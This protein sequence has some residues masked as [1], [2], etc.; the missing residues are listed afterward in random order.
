MI[1]T[2]FL[3]L[4][5]FLPAFR[6]LRLLGQE[7]QG[8]PVSA[9]GL[10]DRQEK[11][12]QG[13]ARGRYGGRWQELTDDQLAALQ[14]RADAYLERLSRRHLREGLVVSLRLDGPTNGAPVAY[15]ALELSAAQTGYLLGVEAL[16][17]AVTRDARPMV[18]ISNLLT[19]VDRLLTSGPRPGFL[20]VFVGAAADPAYRAVFPGYGGEDPKRPGF[21]RWAREGTGSNSV[22]VVW[23]GG[24]DREAYAALNLGLGLVHKLVR[25]TTIRERVTR[26]VGMMLERLREDGWRID[27]GCGRTNFVTP[28]LK[29]ALLCTG[30]NTEPR[31]YLAPYRTTVAEALE[32]PSPALTRYGV[33]SRNVSTFANLFL[34]ARLDPDSSRV[35]IFRQRLTQLW[36]DAEPD[37]NPVLAALFMDAFERRPNNSGA[38]T[39]LQGILAQFPD[40]PRVRV[41]LR[42]SDQPPVR[43]TANGREWVRQAQ[44]LD[45]RP[46]APFQWF[47]TPYRLADDAAS[48]APFVEHPG[49]DFLLAYWL[50][51]DAGLLASAARAEEST[52]RRTG[53]GSGAGENGTPGGNAV[54]GRTNPP[55]RTGG[56]AR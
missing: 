17:F 23:L 45:R 20:P 26:S 15:E 56:P 52:V 35:E 51:K 22:P 37:L 19:G 30:A 25:D 32:L 3:A 38:I 42:D 36:D 12:L 48:P 21:G 50:A 29:A 8:A 11:V 55:A 16:R 31:I 18:G 46:V 28:L 40:P 1:R 43:L 13:V 39:I 6:G 9:S 27:D 53:A 49:V 10:T 14:R 5:V 34:M 24:A 44:L 4:L 33:Y 2:L 41:G 54:R 47:E 7:G